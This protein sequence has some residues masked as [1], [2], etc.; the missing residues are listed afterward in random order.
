MP[1]LQRLGMDLQGEDLKIGSGIGAKFHE[2][3]W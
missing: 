1:F 3:L 2:Q